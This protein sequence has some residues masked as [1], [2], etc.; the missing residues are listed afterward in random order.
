MHYA[1][2][3]YP[4]TDFLEEYQ[5]QN[6]GIIEQVLQLSCDEKTTINT[7][8]QLN[9]TNENRFYDY[10]FHTDNCTTRAKD[11]VVKN[12]GSKV[13]FKSIL[14]KRDVTF[15]KQINPYLDNS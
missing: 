3:V 12:S 9:N 2:S 5:F 7:A 13:T 1:L 14:P 8:L 11:M 6:R 4:F 10:Y 15:R